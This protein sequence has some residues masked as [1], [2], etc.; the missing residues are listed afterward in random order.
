M[1][2]DPACMANTEPAPKTVEGVLDYA[3][4]TLGLIIPASDLIY[5]NGYDL[6]MRGVTS[7]K[8]LGKETVG[9]MKCANPAPAWS[10]GTPS[11]SPQNV[12]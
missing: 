8:V 4:D 10:S 3:R 5:P 2:A 12:L 7:A 9:K 6:L 1:D 11:I